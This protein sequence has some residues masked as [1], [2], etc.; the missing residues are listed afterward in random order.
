M[1]VKQDQDDSIPLFL[2]R[3]QGS[4]PPQGEKNIKNGIGHQ[5]TIHEN[6]SCDEV[7]I[8]F[9]INFM[10]KSI[11][12]DLALIRLMLWACPFLMIVQCM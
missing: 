7:M 5:F 3:F 9:M 11:D 6:R 10:G 2:T 1:I 12:F 8:D 4:I